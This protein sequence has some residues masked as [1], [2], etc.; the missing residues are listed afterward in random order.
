ML[1]VGL[2]AQYAMTSRIVIGADLGI[3]RM[4]LAQVQ[5]RHGVEEQLAP[6]SIQSASIGVDYAIS[7]RVHI[8]GNWQVQHSGYGQSNT[9]TGWYSG[10]YGSWYEPTSRTIEQTLMIGLAYAF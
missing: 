10:M 2:L 8:S 9:V 4:F 7:S 3:G 1:K 6:R 5:S